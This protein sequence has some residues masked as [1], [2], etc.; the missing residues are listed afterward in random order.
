M[1]RSAE[2]ASAVVA[3]AQVIFSSITIYRARGDQIEKYGY[4][5]YGLSAY[6][7]ALMS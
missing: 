6:P 2:V 1:G 3:I 7:Y 4:A 5:A